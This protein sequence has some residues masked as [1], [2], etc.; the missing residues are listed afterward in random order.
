MPIRFLF[1]R[2]QPTSVNPK[3]VVQN[4]NVREMKDDDG[5][6]DFH[7]L[8]RNPRVEKFSVS[9]FCEDA[10]LQEVEKAEAAARCAVDN[11]PNSP[12][13]DMM[14]YDEDKMVLSD[15]HQEVNRLCDLYWIKRVNPPLLYL[16][17]VVMK[18]VDSVTQFLVSNLIPYY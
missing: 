1:C 6:F 16:L 8:L 17:Q 10:T 2:T 13:L 9:I 3:V 5:Y 7:W 12:T 18:L 4:V 15:Q 11:H 14:R